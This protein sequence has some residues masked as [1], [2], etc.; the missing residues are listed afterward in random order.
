MH[1]YIR[2]IRYIFRTFASR[3]RWSPSAFA[4]RPI[5]NF[6]QLFVGFPVRL[7]RLNPLIAHWLI[8]THSWRTH[9][10]AKSFVGIANLLSD[11]SNLVYIW[12]YAYLYA[13]SPCDYTYGGQCIFNA[14]ASSPADEPHW[15]LCVAR[16]TKTIKRRKVWRKCEKNAAKNREEKERERENWETMAEEYWKNAIN[17]HK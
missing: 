3:I 4:L 12:A 17:Y 9:V 2:Y 16:D 1:T 14:A 8:L 10:V 6:T 7:S 15:T 5:I 11:S 13:P